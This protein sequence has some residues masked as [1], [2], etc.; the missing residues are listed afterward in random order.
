MMADK[1]EPTPPPQPQNTTAP[2][3]PKVPENRLVTGEG[4]PPAL[5]AGRTPTG[6]K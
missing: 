2:E 4:I 3:R 1:N 5:I 6:K